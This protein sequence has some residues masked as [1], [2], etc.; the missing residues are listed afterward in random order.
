MIRL[1]T[2]YLDMKRF[3][4]ARQILEQAVATAPT[5]VDTHLALG[6]GR[7]KEK[8]LSMALD[9]YQKAL[10]LEPNNFKVHKGL[11]VTQLLMYQKNPQDKKLLQI[12]LESW[13]H[14]LELNP[15]QANL[16]EW[17]VQYSQEMSPA[18]TVNADVVP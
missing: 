1:G 14:S 3:E 10:K 4:P 17:V 9:C 16:K 15:D 18:R 13:H 6:Y 7:L 8:Q 11:G 12:A 2:A 5:Q